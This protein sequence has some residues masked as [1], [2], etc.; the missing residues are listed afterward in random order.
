M[1]D[2]ILPIGTIVLLKNGIK[3][4]MIAGYIPT[5]LDDNKIYDYSGVPYPEG[6]VDSRKILLFDH[7]QVDKVFHYGYKDE[8]HDQLVEKINNIKAITEDTE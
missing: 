1:K 2:R 3:R 6:L 4:V 5:E 7:N 8:E